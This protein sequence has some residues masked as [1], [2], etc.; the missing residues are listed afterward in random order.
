MNETGKPA[1]Y[2]RVQRL[3]NQT[4]SPAGNKFA[5]FM[6]EAGKKKGR[7][8]LVAIRIMILLASAY[9]RSAV[10]ELQFAPLPG[11]ALSAQQ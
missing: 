1:A 9:A 5:A 11:S 3:G 7:A 4:S 10:A 8:M 6:G 2:Q